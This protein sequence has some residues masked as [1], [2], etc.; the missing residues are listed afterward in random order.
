LQI[1][2]RISLFLSEDLLQDV[3][4]NLAVFCDIV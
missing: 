4:W 1:F 2:N 3:E